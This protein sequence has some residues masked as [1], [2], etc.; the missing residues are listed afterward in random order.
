MN[1]IVV[2]TVVACLIFLLLVFGASLKPLRL[3]GHG[4]IKLMIGAV[5]LFLLN[6]VGTYLN[7]H[8]PINLATVTICGFLGIPGIAALVA[9]EQFIL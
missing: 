6:M 2:I 8:I 1:S 9:I 5:F 7:L 3:L 4:L